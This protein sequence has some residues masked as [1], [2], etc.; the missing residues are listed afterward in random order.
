MKMHS[1]KFKD[2]WISRSEPVA[3]MTPVIEEALRL[4]GVHPDREQVIDRFMSGA[5]R[6]A[7]VRGSE[8]HPPAM[9]SKETARRLL[10]YIWMNGGLPFEITQLFPCEELAH[11]TDGAQYALLSRNSCTA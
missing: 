10:R 8:D 6:V 9:G 4:A 11:A 5:P 1:S 3:L 7:V 2:P